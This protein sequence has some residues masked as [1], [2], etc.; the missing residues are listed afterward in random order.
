[1]RETPLSTVKRVYGSKDKLV[2]AVIDTAKAVGDDTSDAKDRLLSISNKKLLRLAEV[3]KEVKEKYGN[4]DK[5]VSAIATALGRAKDN[6][7]VEKLKT[8]STARLADMARVA[9]RK[10][11]N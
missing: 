7:Y 5:M 2:D 1:M 9:E 6:D 10:A 8:F 3:G 4:R 11:S